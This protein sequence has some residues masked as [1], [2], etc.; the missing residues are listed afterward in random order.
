MP[1]PYYFNPQVL[2]LSPKFK[3]ILRIKKIKRIIE[4]LEK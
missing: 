1:F 2:N 3:K 4:K